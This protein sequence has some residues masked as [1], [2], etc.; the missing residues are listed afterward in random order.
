[1]TPNLFRSKL[2]SGEMKTVERALQQVEGLVQSLRGAGEGVND[3]SRS[4][5]RMDLVFTSGLTPSWE[6]EA[7]LVKLYLSLGL[8][9]AALDTALKLEMWETVIDCYH[10]IDLRHKAADVI[11]NKINKDGNYQ[12]LYFS[13]AST[14]FKISLS[15]RISFTA[16]I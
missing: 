5:S 16:I 15:S 12:H 2:E 14:H 13:K 6:V 1:M 8:T 7:D 3:L 11:R 4:S 10:R 9:K